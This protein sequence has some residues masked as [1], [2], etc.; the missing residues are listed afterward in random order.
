M[1]GIF[2]AF[3]FTVLTAR[4]ELCFIIEFASTRFG[5]GSPR[6]PLPKGCQ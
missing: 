6:W 3:P 5:I 2:A 4:L 1:I